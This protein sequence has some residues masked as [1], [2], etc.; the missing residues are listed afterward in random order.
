MSGIL[1][2]LKLSYKQ[3]TSLTK[4][5]YINIIVF[6]IVNLTLVMLKLFKVEMGFNLIHWLSVPANIGTLITRP[7][8]VFTYMFLHQSFLH[9]LFNMLWLYWFGR[10]FLQ[11]LDQKKLLNV[12]ILGGLSGAAFFILSYNVFPLFSDVKAVSFA[13]G[14]SASVLAVVIAI[15]VLKPNY[16]INLLFFGPVKLKYI[17]IITILID[18]LSIAGS[19]AGGHLAHLGGAL[20]GYL[21]VNQY[22]K[23]GKDITRKF[24]NFMDALAY[25]FKSRIKKEKVYVS[26][27]KPKTDYDYNKEKAKKQ[28]E[29]DKILDKIAK[30]GY[31]SLTKEE[32][33]LLFNASKDISNN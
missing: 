5:I 8:T 24:G 4:L 28:E 1:D 10:I 17:A 31:K 22:S 16:E 13:L 2:E 33:N 15:S 21:F 14:A 11:Y 29:I 20:F 6:V 18:V 30:S 23:Q 32:K 9:I 25:L 26:Y 3:G 27:K 7:W 19:N 12:Y